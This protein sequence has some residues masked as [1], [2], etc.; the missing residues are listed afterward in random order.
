MER[1]GF[2]DSHGR[3]LILF[4][5]LLLLA[6]VGLLIL[7]PASSVVSS[8]MRDD[9]AYYVK[10][11]GLW[12]A[13]GFGAMLLAVV[14]PLRKLQGAAPFL[15]GLHILFLLAVFLPGI[16][17]SVASSRES[18]HRWIGIGPVVFQPSEFAKIAIILYTARILS[19][20]GKMEREFSIR[21]FFLPAGL[22]SAA[23]IAIILEPQYGTTLCI[24]MA[25]VTVVFISG[26]P[27][28]RLAVLFLSMIPILLLVGFLGEY[29]LDRFRVWLDP[30]QYRLEGG[31]QLVTSFRSFHEGG[32]FGTDLS[33]G[34]GHRFLTYGHTDF[35]LALLAE[36]Y[37]WLG[38]ILLLALFLSFLWRAGILLQHVED[39]FS[40]LLGTGSLVM[41]ISQALLNMAVVTG[42]LPT[43]GVSLPFI[44]YGGSSL[45]ASLIFGGLILNATAR[46]TGKHPETEGVTEW[47]QETVRK[48]SSL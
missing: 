38:V 3:D 4:V 41:L 23:L 10:R 34:F 19:R 47:F 44:S 29:R 22:L 18:F 6:G 45:I 33:T 11:Q 1:T 12:L 7:Y 36:D 46:I 20:D 27:L 26:F 28:I 14:L 42:I 25:L 35:I 8:I 40:F 2:Q 32:I 48:N 13:M 5:L 30:Y 39:P 37:G 31:Y 9:P 21:K 16:G 15:L 17:H 24:L 43:T